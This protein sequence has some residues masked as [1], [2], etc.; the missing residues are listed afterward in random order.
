MKAMMLI[1]LQKHNFNRALQGFD[2][3]TLNLFQYIKQFN[4]LTD[5]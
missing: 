1:S 3:N 2:D 5:F 4:V